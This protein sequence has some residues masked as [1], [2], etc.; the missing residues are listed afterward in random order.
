MLTFV[1]VFGT[2]IGALLAL[3]WLLRRRRGPR[4]DEPDEEPLFVPESFSDPLPEL[5]AG[6][7][8]EGRDSW[9]HTRRPLPWMIALFLAVIWLTPFDNIQLK[10][11]LPVELRL[12]RLVLPFVVI[13]WLLALAAGGRKAPRLKMT[14][15]HVALARAAGDGVP[16]RGHR[17]PVPQPHARAAAVAEEAPADRLLRARCS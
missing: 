7:P 6:D 17:R 15:I 9:P 4:S 1:T 8:S 11:S 5:V 16:Q 13:V 12:D 3:G 14:W 10:A 2:M